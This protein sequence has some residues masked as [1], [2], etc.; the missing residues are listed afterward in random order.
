MDHSRHEDYQ[1]NVAENLAK[2]HKRRA[3]APKPELV[4][5]ALMLMRLNLDPLIPM[6]AALYSDSPR[7][8]PPF[9][10]VCMLRA[11][12]LMTMLR[13][14]SI[15][16]FAEDLRRKPRL[17]IL[18]GFAPH[19]T[20]CVGALYLFID[21][22]EDGPF[23]P[24]CEHRVP[25]S[26]LRKGTHLRDLK[27]E[28]ADKEA[29]RKQILQQCD[30]ITRALKAQLLDQ[31]S[32]PRPEDFLKR[33]EDSLFTTAIIP[34]AS[35]GMLG[36]LN[37]LNLCGDGSALPTGASSSGKPSCQC[38]KEGN[39][40]CGCPRFYADPTADWGF[41]SYRET[42]YFGHTFYQH[43][44]SFGGHDLPVHLTLGPA[45]ESDFTL[46]LNSL[47]RFLKGCDEHQLPVSVYA[48]IYD[49]GHD[50]FGIYEFLQAKEINPVIALNPRTGQHPKPSG[51]AEQVNDQGI[52]VCPAGLEMRRHSSTP[53]HRIVFNCPVKRPTHEDGK[54]VW[55]SHVEECP[56]KVLCQP[57]T[58]MGPTVYV[59]SDSD[60]RF[61]PKI[62]RD[63]AEY[64]ALF[65]QRTGCERSNSTKKVTNHLENRPCRSATHYLMRLY[66]ISIVEH[67]KAWVAEDR[68]AWGDD[69]EILS[70]IERINAAVAPR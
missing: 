6:L 64:K 62:A 33:L 7:G 56:H 39:Y 40:K 21:R 49:A 67:A 41:D 54:T 3:R 37:R 15:T 43:I 59:R 65:A 34:S 17:A 27:Q 47:D 44:V 26:T 4:E 5:A 53:N 38:R 9:D 25:L 16:K 12:L 61:Y 18:A 58:Q 66:L 11:L 29:H 60:P 51:T 42:Y 2:W 45:S 8:R 36:D 20:P 70:N 28:K 50:A 48:A 46:S 57:L 24:K 35:R 30:S 55:K 23:Q 10:P 14:T 31:A 22:L 32:Q 63:S 19:E 13:Y 52:P 1:K 69:W 68:A